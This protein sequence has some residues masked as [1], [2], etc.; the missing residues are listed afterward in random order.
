[1]KLTIMHL[2]HYAWLL[3]SLTVMCQAAE[4]PAPSKPHN[5]AWLASLTHTPLAASATFDGNGRLWLASVKDGHVYVSY[6]DDWGKTTST[7]VMVNAEAE[8]VAANGENRPKILVAGNGNIFVSYTRSLETPYA[9]NIRFSRSVDAGRHFSAPVT[10]NDNQEPITHAFEAM[11]INQR[12]QIYL[13]WLDRRDAADARKKGEKYSGLAVYYAV[14]DDEGKSFQVNSKA[15]DHACECCRVALAMDNDGIPVILWRQIY[16]KNVRDHAMLKLDGKSPALRVS[17]ENW[18]LDACPHHGPA[19]SIDS[20]GVYHFVW[21]SNAPQK[22]G[23]FYAHTSDHGQHFSSAL[24]FG[25]FNAQATHPNVLSLGKRVFIVWK[26][27]DG[28]STI[29]N[30]MNSLD[31][32]VHWTAPSKIADTTDASDHPWLINDSKHAYLSWN[33][34]SEG[35]RLIE[36][37]EQ[38]P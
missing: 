13:A 36:L 22:H 24:N 20:D 23:L 8:Y 28:K 17:S 31:S 35:Y 25:N 38:V 21:F 9:G 19:A 32:G 37:A 7:A 27:F 1:M 15:A 4:M 5:A 14:S 26:E 30:M 11:G 29:I 3:T 18:E 34:L 33:T 10:V 16:D 2:C 12:G 6:S